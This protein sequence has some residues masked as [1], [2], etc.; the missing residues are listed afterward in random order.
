M[1]HLG[2][3]SFFGQA[4][5]S[6]WL[7]FGGIWLFVGVVM[8]IGSA[9]M[10]LQERSWSADSVRTTGIV[11]TK[12]ISLADSD[13]ST[14][15]R[16]RFRFTSKD[17]STIEGDE[18]VEVA[19]WEGLTERGPIEVYYLPSSPSSVRLEPGESP[20]G[21]LI[22]F[23]VGVV[24]GGIGGFLFVRAAL[25][26]LRARR[27]LHSGIDAEATVTGVE[28]T[29]VSFNRQPQFRV[30]YS[31]RDRQGGRHSGDSGYLDWEEASRW[32][33]GDHV[34]IRHDPQ[35]PAESVWIGKI[36]A[37]RPTIDA[38]PPA[39]GAPPPA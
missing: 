16:V 26:L 32:T 22:L 19:T 14:A 5:R 17:G 30:R 25:E 9:G 31:Y 11:L 4:K 39:V 2:L 34:A 38:A 29:N 6:F 12:D 20:I 37:P 8:L 33:K 27:L 24:F 7:Y 35:R 21:V 13:S 36:Q 10:A 28:G 1:S 15:Y 23:L 3:P 18:Q